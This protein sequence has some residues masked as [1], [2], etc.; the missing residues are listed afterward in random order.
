MAPVKNGLNILAGISGKK[1]RAYKE[2]LVENYR[3]TE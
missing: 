1:K 2:R 3:Q